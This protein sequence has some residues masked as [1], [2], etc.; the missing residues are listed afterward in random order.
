MSV[1]S[2]RLLQHH[3]AMFGKQ[4]VIGVGEQNNRIHIDVAGFQITLEDFIFVTSENPAEPQC[5]GSA[6]KRHPFQSELASRTSIIG[7]RG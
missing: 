5:R 4:N 6:T 1:L 3:T 2:H 7:V